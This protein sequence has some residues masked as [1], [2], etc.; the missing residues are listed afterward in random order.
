MAVYRCSPSNLVELRRICYEEWDKL[1]KPRYE[2]LIETFPRRLRAV[3]AI[4]EASTKY[5]I[6]GSE[7]FCQLE[8]LVFFYF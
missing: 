6:E 2:R 4:K 3:I 1:P 5:R 7:Y 8:I